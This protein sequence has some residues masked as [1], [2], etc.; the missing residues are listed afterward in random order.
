MFHFRVGSI[1][2]LGFAQSEVG[3][4]V[5]GRLSCPPAVATRHWAKRLSIRDFC[6]TGIHM[7][8]RNRLV[9]IVMEL[10]AERTNLLNQLKDVDAALAGLGKLDTV[11]SSAKPKRRWSAKSRKRLRLARKA[12]WAKARR[13]AP[14]VGPGLIRVKRTILV[15][16]GKRIAV[17]ARHAS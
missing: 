14:P 11:G 7:P 6:R 4:C 10:R 2:P 12:R 1:P 5:C 15:A 17:A 9:R 16:G 13:G 8:H 3:Q